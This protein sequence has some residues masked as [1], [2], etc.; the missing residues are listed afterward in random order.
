MEVYS[1]D[2]PYKWMIFGK[3]RFTIGYQK[4][5]EHGAKVGSI[6]KVYH[7]QLGFELV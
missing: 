2:K 1:W 5:I 6:W 7:Q 3:Y 4:M